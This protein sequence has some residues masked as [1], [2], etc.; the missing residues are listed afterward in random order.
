[1]ALATILMAHLLSSQTMRE[2]ESLKDVIYLNLIFF[3]SLV[4]VIT[5]TEEVL[6]QE[7]L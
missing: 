7:E 3:Q 2:E 6:H 4:Q 1:M 5:T